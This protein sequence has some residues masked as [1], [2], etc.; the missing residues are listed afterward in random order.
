MDINFYLRNVKDP[1]SAIIAYIKTNGKRYKLSVDYSVPT[2][3]WDTKKQRLR[4]GATATDGTPAPIVNLRLDNIAR[5]FRQIEATAPLTKEQIQQRLNLLIG[6]IKPEE[7]RN[8]NK[9]TLDQTL[10]AF[11]EQESTRNGWCHGTRQ[12]FTTLRHHLHAIATTPYIEDIDNDYLDTFITYCVKQNYANSYTHKLAR[13]LIW[14]LRWCEKK[15]YTRK[16]DYDHLR[17]KLAMPKKPIIFLQTEELERL[18]KLTLSPGKTHLQRA[19]DFFL[20]CCYTG[21]RYSDARRVSQAD[22]KDNCL[23]LITQ[24]DTDSLVI[25]LLPQAQNILQKYHRPHPND[26]LLPSIPNPVLNEQI[27]ILCA[28]AD[29]NAPVTRTEIRG[30][31]RSE[32]TLPKYETISSHCGRRTFICY[33]LAQGVP[34]NVVMAITGHSDYNAMK[35][36]IAIAD[37]TIKNAMQTIARNLQVAGIE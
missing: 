16:L 32:Q 34:P 28:M 6:K 13:I 12:K 29:I 30:S 18:S 22:I 2:P 1:E 17:P 4:P 20:F 23:N 5:E 37:Q 31:N 14:F 27:K 9:H 19:L 21:L 33:A 15:S 10:A 8:Q 11:V 24:K 35:P 3:K 7:V 36:Y 26:K 25:P